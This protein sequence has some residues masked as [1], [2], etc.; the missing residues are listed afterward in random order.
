MAFH[1]LY[2]IFYY[3]SHSFVTMLNTRIFIFLCIFKCIDFTSAVCNVSPYKEGVETKVRCWNTLL[4]EVLQSSGSFANVI[5]VLHSNLGSL[6]GNSFAKYGK[7]LTLLSFQNCSISSIHRDAFADLRYLKKL[8]L[9]HNKIS[10]LHPDIFRSLE[11]LE[12]LDLEF[13]SIRHIEDTLF[14]KLPRLKLLNLDDNQLTCLK[15]EGIQALNNLVQIRILENPLSLSCRGRLTLWLR[16][17][18]INYSNENPTK[19][20]NWLDSLLWRCAMEN[21]VTT[22]SEDEMR[23]CIIFYMFNQL[24]SAVQS[25]SDYSVDPRTCSNEVD[26]FLQSIESTT[27]FG[28]PIKNGQAIEIMMYALRN[29]IMQMN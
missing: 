3:I 10:E 1:I 23:R 16:D 2:D 4:K 22:T 17:H 25:T 13:N 11:S 26:Q 18:G 19:K 14:S 12:Y 24:K 5:T 9:S 21:P 27:Q 28:K 8:T 7:S 15:P 6:E 20:E 29:T